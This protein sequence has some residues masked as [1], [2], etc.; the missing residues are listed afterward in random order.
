MTAPNGHRPCAA[1]SILVNYQKLSFWVVN[2]QS[3]INDTLQNSF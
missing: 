3:V 2:N 1:L